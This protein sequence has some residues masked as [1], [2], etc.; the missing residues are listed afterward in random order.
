LRATQPKAFRGLVGF[1]S[2]FQTAVPRSTKVDCSLKSTRGAGSHAGRT[3]NL[4]FSLGENSTDPPTPHGGEFC[5]KF[6]APHRGTS[7]GPFLCG[8]KHLHRSSKW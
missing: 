2:T 8:T 1:S 3:R 6:R 7:L 5:S 4:P